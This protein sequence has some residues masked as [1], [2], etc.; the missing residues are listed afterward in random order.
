MMNLHVLVFEKYGNAM[1]SGMSENKSVILFKVIS[2]QLINWVLI[3]V[4]DISMIKYF[5]HFNLVPCKTSKL[6]VATF[7][8]IFC[9]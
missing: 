5:I 9:F 2:Q 4:G 6:M 7:S 1:N 8:A 3:L